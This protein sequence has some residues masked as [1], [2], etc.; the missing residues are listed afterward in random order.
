VLI[1]G[2]GSGSR[3]LPGLRS[4]TRGQLPGAG[5]PGRRRYARG[6]PRWFAG[7]G[8][9]GRLTPPEFIGELQQK[10]P[11]YRT[12]LTVQPGLTGWAQTHYHYGNSVDDALMKL[13]YDLYYL[14]YQSLWLDLYIIFRTFGVVLTSK[15]T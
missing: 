7:V 1:V 9:R 4:E 6:S 15:G 3:P 2:E 14:R 10:I 13:Q 5:L 12:R 8:P 11:F